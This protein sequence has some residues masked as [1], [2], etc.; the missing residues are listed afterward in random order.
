MINH[1]FI[2]LFLIA[3]ASI[4]STH[5]LNDLFRAVFAFDKH[6][7]CCFGNILVSFNSLFINL[8][9]I[10]LLA[11]HLS[12][13]VEKLTLWDIILIVAMLFEFRFYFTFFTRKSMLFLLLSPR[14]TLIHIVI[15]FR[16]AYCLITEG[17][18]GKVGLP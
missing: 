12:M 7:F 9:A 16:K 15:G 13:S 17:S 18:R 8:P 3:F 10:K 11:L 1:L 5:T 4:K 6:F 2:I 14:K